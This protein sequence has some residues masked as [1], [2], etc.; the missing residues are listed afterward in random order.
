ME[1]I[2]KHR[3]K[4][5]DD[6]INFNFLNAFVQPFEH[7]NCQQKKSIMKSILIL[8]FV[9]VFFILL[10]S[11][12]KSASI[13][14]GSIVGKWNIQKDSIYTGVG[15]NN[16]K[17]I[18]SGQPDDYFNFTSDGNLYTRENS[19]LDTLSYTINSDSVI[20]QDFG[21]G[22]GIGKGQFQSSAT[23][24]LIISSG[25]LLTPGGIFGRTVYLKR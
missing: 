3:I 4:K 6:S 14:P 5:N 16:Q 2:A 25:Y 13:V 10:S 9:I 15:N 21:Y 8:L 19:I 1:E 11:C 18:Y 23:H 17:V 20:I 7:F 22:G 12:K 24:S